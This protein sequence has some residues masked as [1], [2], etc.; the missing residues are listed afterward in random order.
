MRPLTDFQTQRSD[1][2][3]QQRASDLRSSPDNSKYLDLSNSA[4]NSKHSPSVTVIDEFDHTRPLL[5]SDSNALVLRGSEPIPS[6]NAAAVL[7]TPDRRSPNQRNA[8]ETFKSTHFHGHGH[9]EPSFMTVNQFELHMLEEVRAVYARHAQ[10]EPPPAQVISDSMRCLDSLILE[11]VHLFMAPHDSAAFQLTRLALT[12]DTEALSLLLFGHQPHVNAE[13]V[14]ASALDMQAWKMPPA[15][16]FVQAY[17]AAA[18]N[19]WVFRTEF[20]HGWISANYRARKME[21]FISR[22]WSIA[23][24]CVRCEKADILR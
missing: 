18:I 20:R 19:E 24:S 16:I 1:V 21:D 12:K 3:G 7:R 17:I 11:A 23:R 4:L 22:G 5:A 15:S 6:I 14:I 10:R 9:C 2:D 13:V 8:I